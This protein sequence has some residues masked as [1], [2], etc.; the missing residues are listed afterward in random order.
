MQTPRRSMDDTRIVRNNRQGVGNA[1]IRNDEM[2]LNISPHFAV[3][4]IL[5][6]TIV[7][8]TCGTHKNLYILTLFTNNIW[9]C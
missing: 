2:R 5:R 9:S 4:P 6:G 1:A 8:R 7:S 3:K